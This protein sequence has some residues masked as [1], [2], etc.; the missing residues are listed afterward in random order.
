MLVRG[1]PVANGYA[2]AVAT[3]ELIDANDLVTSD[4][5]NGGPDRGPVPVGFV[6]QPE[7]G[8]GRPSSERADEGSG[9]G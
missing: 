3:E 9:R 5:P 1:V 2:E 8:A 4:P 7:W 6:V